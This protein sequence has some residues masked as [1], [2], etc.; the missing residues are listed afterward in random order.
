MALQ[1]FTSLIKDMGIFFEGL[2]EE[3]EH[4]EGS[5]RC[6]LLEI[7]FEARKGLGGL[8]GPIERDEAGIFGCDRFHIY[9]KAPPPHPSG[10]RKFCLMATLGVAFPEIPKIFKTPNVPWHVFDIGFRK[11][12]LHVHTFR[13]SQFKRLAVLAFLRIAACRASRREGTKFATIRQRAVTKRPA[14]RGLVTSCLA[15]LKADFVPTKGIKV[16]INLISNYAAEIVLIAGFV[17]LV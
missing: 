17:A 5:I 10:A 8:L 16:I 7:L 14:L 15:L 2:I 9:L 12:P 13:C 1:H 6:I 3:S 11:V 4:D